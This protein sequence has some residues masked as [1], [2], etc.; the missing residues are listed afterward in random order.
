VAYQELT[1]DPTT[2]EVIE[3]I[4]REGLEPQLRDLHALLRLPIEQIGLVSGCNFVACHTLLAILSGI[5]VMLFNQRG[6]SG[7]LFNR[8]LNEIY[9]P[10]DPPFGVE[11]KDASYILYKEFRNPLTHSIG[12]SIEHNRGQRK[13]EPR[14]NQFVIEKVGGLEEGAIEAIE[15]SRDRPRH[16]QTLRVANG[17]TVLLVEGLYWGVRRTI[18]I[19]TRHHDLMDQAEVFLKPAFPN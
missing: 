12:I 5:S 7:E 8:L 16:I 6:G 18:E 3:R 17:R 9:W 19:L 11:P 10:I 1:L 15:R 4:I 14:Q 2:P 13:I